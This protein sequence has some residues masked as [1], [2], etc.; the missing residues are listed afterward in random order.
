M[1]RGWTTEKADC[2]STILL[3]DDNPSDRAMFRRILRSGGHTVHEVVRGADVLACIKELRPHVVVLD[4][5]LPDIDGHEICRMLRKDPLSTGIPVLILTVRD[6]REDVVAGLTAGADD[7]VL[8]DEAVEIILARVNRL[9]D[10]RKLSSIAVINEQLA[11]IGRLLAGIVH[12]IR[13]PLAVIR[14]HAE[15]MQLV[16]DGNAQV[17]EYV[18]PIL[19]NSILLQ[20]RLDH[21]MAAVRTGPASPHL[22]AVNPIVKEA[23][24][25]FKRG[26]DPRRK[27][28]E[29][30]VDATEGRMMVVVDA[31]RLIQVMLNLL[32][33]AYE[34][35]ADFDGLGQ[36]SVSVTTEH[37]EADWARIDVVD[38]GPGI[39]PQLLA[40]LFEPF[41]T[42]K[43][44]GSGYGLYLAHEIIREQGGRLEASNG[45]QG[46]ACFTIW[47]PLAT[48]AAPVSRGE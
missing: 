45:P 6:Q 34:A 25:L 30:V 24:D 8:K 4:V 37:G 43:E 1:R 47:L 41:F 39:P 9:A 28:V 44:E 14:G 3:V 29:I 38:N 40:R 10:Y 20:S 5:N 11:Q 22:I 2:M 17:Q 12:E 7:Y 19:R 27:Q 31:G 48:E 23:T 15:L 35:M 36:I 32:A 46:G 42:T 21:L 33:N 16:L 18:E 13:S 26:L